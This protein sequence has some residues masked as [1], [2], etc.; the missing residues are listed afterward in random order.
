MIQ[1]TQVFKNWSK[2]RSVES[3]NKTSQNQYFTDAQLDSLLRMESISSPFWYHQS[4]CITWS[5][6]SKS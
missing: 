4:E 3:C 6:S 1:K 5:W 2:S